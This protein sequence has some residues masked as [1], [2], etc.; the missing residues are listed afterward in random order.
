[1][2]SI[3]QSLSEWLHAPHARSALDN[4]SRD[5]LA[6]YIG[7]QLLRLPHIR[8]DYY[9]AYKKAEQKRFEIIKGFVAGNNPEHKEF[10]N[11]NSL[12]QDDDY[13]SVVHSE[14]YAN[15]ALIDGMQ[16]RL[17]EKTWAFLVSETNDLCTSDFPLVVV[18]L[19]PRQPPYYN[20]VG[21]RGAQIVIPITGNLVISMWDTNLFDYAKYQA[22]QFQPI[23]GKD[24]MLFN[25]YQYVNAETNIFC[26]NNSFDFIDN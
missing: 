20:G 22:E 11:T 13:A 16:D 8:N 10:I 23:S 25:L 1:M 4:V 3:K 9:Q 14:I 19:V 7:I 21:M 6:G 26:A 2:S 12:N 18:P 15:Q 5:L 17:R 24:K